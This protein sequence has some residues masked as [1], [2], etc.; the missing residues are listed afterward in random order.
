[1]LVFSLFVCVGCFVCFCCLV[2]LL[3]LLVWL[4]VRCLVD[5]FG[6]FIVYV[7]VVGFECGLIVIGLG[8]VGF[9]VALC[10]GLMCWVC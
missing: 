4:L 7:C 1:M 5:W 6:G 9:C 2:G 8:L 3:F 10:L